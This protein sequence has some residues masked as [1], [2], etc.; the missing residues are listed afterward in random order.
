MKSV[1]QRVETVFGWFIYLYGKISFTFLGK[2]MYLEAP[3]PWVLFR[4]TLLYMT[5]VNSCNVINYCFCVLYTFFK[6]SVSIPSIVCLTLFLGWEIRRHST[7]HGNTKYVDRTQLHC[8]LLPWPRAPLTLIKRCW[9]FISKKLRTLT[10]Q[11]KRVPPSWRPEFQARLMS[12]L[13]G[14]YRIILLSLNPFAVNSQKNYSKANLLCFVNS[15]PHFRCFGL[16]LL[17]HIKGNIFSI[18]KLIY[19]LNNR[20]KQAMEDTDTET[21][22]KVLKSWNTEW[23]IL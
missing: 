23:N 21:I 2:N 7:L 3:L 14:Y 18:L 10:S 4:Y 5:S 15:T 12:S 13:L 19:Q 16:L 17:S 11:C 20:I 8:P 1:L 22:G 6:V 9:T